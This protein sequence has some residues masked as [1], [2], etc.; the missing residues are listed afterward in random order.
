[1]SDCG[2]RDR[3]QS[4]WQHEIDADSNAEESDPFP[5]SRQGIRIVRWSCGGWLHRDERFDIGPE[6]QGGEWGREDRG[7]G[8]AD[9][10]R[11][12][13]TLPT[14]SIGD[15]GGREPDR[16]D[17]QQAVEDPEEG[18]GGGRHPSPA[19]MGEHPCGLSTGGET[20][21]GRVALAT[22]SHASHQS[23]GNQAPENRSST[24]PD[25]SKHQPTEQQQQPRHQDDRGEEER[26]VDGRFRGPHQLGGGGPAG[27]STGHGKSS[28]AKDG[29]EQ[30]AIDDS[31]RRQ[32][33][34]G[35]VIGLPGGGAGDAIPPG[36]GLR[37]RGCR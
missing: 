11:Q 35:F 1:M 25:Q 13:G 8:S 22:A 12:P 4:H 20:E 7:R 9:R 15:A 32:D 34:R 14:E 10:G 19:A 24:G 31:L 27:E 5:A 29:G 21:G 37:N 23:K 17:G 3:E 36:T 18:A 28:D 30:A 2:I 6:G 16:H 26:R 33:R